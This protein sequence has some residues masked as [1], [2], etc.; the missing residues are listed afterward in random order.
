MSSYE[1]PLPAIEPFS[2][3]YWEAARRH[4]FVIQRCK[5]CGTFR[6]Y[7]RVFCIK[8]WSANT[9]WVKTSGHGSVYTYTV[10]Q[11]ATHSAF[12]KDVPY[13]YAIIELKEGPHM[14]S[15]IVGCKPEEVRIG[16]AVEVV[17]DDVTNEIAL[18]KFRLVK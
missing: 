4:E 15:N 16:A 7:P 18:P 1:K 17:F 11:R 10:V 2:K 12:T 14:S 6:F 13:V 3:P 8:C 9:E 5:D